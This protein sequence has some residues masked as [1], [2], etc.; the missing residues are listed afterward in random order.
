MA[1]PSSKGRNYF[2]TRQTTTES[3]KKGR[4]PHNVW[5]A[6]RRK[7]K[8]QIK[9]RYLRSVPRGAWGA[10]KW[11][12]GWRVWYIYQASI[13]RVVTFFEL[14]LDPEILKQSIPKSL[15]SLPRKYV[16]RL[17]GALAVRGWVSGQEQETQACFKR[18][19]TLMEP[20]LTPN[21]VFRI[22][23]WYHQPCK[24]VFRCKSCWRGASEG[25]SFAI[26]RGVCISWFQVVSK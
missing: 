16:L 26:F 9:A 23:A 19:G 12:R 18:V 21:H 14:D 10:G 5:N 4:N 22:R 20:N 11:W 17:W 1:R 7:V 6:R 15:V 2:L 13:E 3:A 8:N 24:R 25:D